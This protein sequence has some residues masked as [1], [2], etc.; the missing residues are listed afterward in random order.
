M[1]FRLVPTSVTL[2]DLQWRSSL[3]C[4]ISPNSIALEA[5]YVTVVVDR[6]IKSNGECHLP[7]IFWPKLI[8][9]AVARFLCDS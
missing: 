7:L 6:L 9:V 1:G 4:V 5:D 2:N 8:H 3:F